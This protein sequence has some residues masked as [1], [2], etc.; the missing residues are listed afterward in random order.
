MAA[1]DI[2]IAYAASSNLDVTSL[3][4][5]DSSQTWVLGWESAAIDNTTNKYRD[6]LVTGKLVAEGANNQVGQIRV[7]VVAM[8]D[9]S[10]WPDVFDG[11]ESTETVSTTSI[12]DS[13]CKLGAVMATTADASG[14]YLFG[15]FSVAS[16]FGGVCPAKFVIFITG[17]PTSSGDGFEATGTPHQ[18]TIKGIYDTLAV[19]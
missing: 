7:Y 16:L 3:P 9:D 2:K 10:T 12:R 6:Y 13:I 11:T 8:L 14:T 19:S 18:V 17:N 1:G 4:G 15:P 5:L